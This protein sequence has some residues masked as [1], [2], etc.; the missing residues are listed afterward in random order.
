MIVCESFHLGPVNI[1]PNA[2]GP[3]AGFGQPLELVSRSGGSSCL[4]TLTGPQ[5]DFN[6]GA[7]ITQGLV[8]QLQGRQGSRW[9]NLRQ[10]WAPAYSIGSRQFLQYQ[11]AAVEQFR[12]LIYLVKSGFDPTTWATEIRDFHFDLT[13]GDAGTGGVAPGASFLL[14]GRV[15]ATPA[16]SDQ[17]SISASPERRRLIVEL[18]DLGAAASAGCAWMPSDLTPAAWVPLRLNEPRVFETSA[19]LWVGSDPAGT[20]IDVSVIEELA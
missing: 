14:T 13:T 12:A 4:L 3:N 16:G 9:T 10:G 20:A 1:R 2:G 6:T 7:R 19:P 11:G 17:F 18:V 8:A 15:G 5:T